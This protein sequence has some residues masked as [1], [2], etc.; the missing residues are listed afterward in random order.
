MKKIFAILLILAMV[1]PMCV[2]TNAAESE[3]GI[4]PFYL[5]NTDRN[6]EEDEDNIYPKIFFW[7]QASDKY[8]TEDSIRVSVPGVGGSTP[9]E[10]A[11]NLKPVFDN[12]PDGTRYLRFGSLGAAL[13]VLLE[14]WVYMEKGAAVMNKW[15]TEF[16]EYYHSIGGK[17]DGLIVDLEYFE[18]STYYTNMEAQ[19]D[20]YLYKK[21]VENPNYETKL[22]PA[23]EER[24]FKFWTKVTDETPEIYSI[25]DSAGS[26]YSQSKSIWN[27][28]LRN[29]VNK[30]IDDALLE[31]L[32]AYYPNAVL[33]DYQSR[34]TYAWNKDLGDKGGYTTGGNYQTVGNASYFNT[35]AARPGTGFFKED[36]VPVY[37][38]IPSYNGTIWADTAYNMVMWDTIHYKSYYEAAPDN[39]TTAIV[40]YYQYNNRPGGYCDTPYYSEMFY[41]VCMLDPQPLQGYCMESEMKA[42]NTD[43][44][45][46]MQIISEL[47]DE[48]TRIC[49]AA[50]RK[51]IVYK[52]SWNDKFILSGMYAGGKNYWRI[53]P[54]T[55]GTDTTLESFK[56]AGT[57]DPTFS[58]Q[59]QTITFP[60]GKIIEDAK[61]S[62]VGTC[63]YWVETD[64]NVTPVVTY[65]ENRYEQYPA[66]AQDFQSMALGEFNFNTAEP[67][68]CWE[69]K[70]DKTSSAKI[71]ADGSNQVL[72]MSGTYSL[73]LKEILQN[74]TA[75]DSYA[76]NQTWEIDVTVPANMAADAEIILMD[77]Y[78]AKVKPEA[79]GFKIA[80]GKIYY[81]QAGSYVE[82]AGVDVSAG[83]T[84]KLKRCLDFTQENAYTSDYAVYDAAGALLA[85]VKD[86][87][88]ATTLKLP[89]EKVA[90]SVSKVTGDPVKLDNLK[91]YA[92]GVA[93]DF[94]LYDF[95]TGIEVK[96]EDMGLARDRKTAYRLSWM[97]ATKY[98]KVYSVIAEYSD[99]TTKVLK[100]IKMAPGTDFVD[101]GIVDVAA[102]QTVK[103]Y[104]R[105]DSQP[106]PDGTV[107]PNAGV[108]P[109]ANNAKKSDTTM[110]ILIVA[111]GVLF[112][113]VVVVGMVILMKKKPA[114]AAEAAETTE[115]KTEE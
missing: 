49:G 92:S 82:L 19:K 61:I 16:I 41:H 81:D 4:K 67:V 31:P 43:I 40:V 76:E 54:D 66:Y 106:E 11:E 107:D 71:V 102:G 83:G 101:T 55:I 88:L 57:T 62:E 104:I 56:V 29:H 20:M 99:G 34:S 25:S 105:N 63:G 8:V 96:A 23:L 37:K 13:K 113:A 33:S 45:L 77:I 103:V 115:T 36:G 64:Q 86:V 7:S 39:K 44:A 30:Y 93:T 79:G 50:D 108:T 35:Y 73:K 70:K 72:E 27:V 94:E 89:V 53:T 65:A 111:V 38:N 112:V 51:P 47:L 97:N 17:I 9:K 98:E 95:E 1:L 114:P 48:M 91:M 85:E 100:E 14:D 24:G 78:S 32:L 60:G 15:F 90:F 28:V 74:I 42:T 2:M 5:V 10:I 75:G 18:L 109:D 110:L 87:A 58:I 46:A 68:G 52:N 69:V 12:Y 80:G 59:G 22:R 26:E 84:Y 6:V 21:I 3:V